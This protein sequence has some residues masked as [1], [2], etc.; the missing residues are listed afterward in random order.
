[1]DQWNIWSDT[2]LLEMWEQ[3]WGEKCPRNLLW[4]TTLIGHFYNSRLKKHSLDTKEEGK[5]KV[6]H[7]ILAEQFIDIWKGI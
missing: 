4:N 3:D 2:E 5:F 6:R 7:M 1:M